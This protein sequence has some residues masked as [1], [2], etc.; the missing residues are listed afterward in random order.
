MPRLHPLKYEMF[1]IKNMEV[2]PQK[3]AAPGMIRLYID[4]A[5]RL[6]T[7]YSHGINIALSLLRKI[8]RSI[9]RMCPPRNGRAPAIGALD[10]LVKIRRAKNLTAG[11]GWIVRGFNFSRNA[12]IGQDRYSRMDTG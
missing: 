10:N 1:F 4:A 9:H 3:Y 6:H 5:C 12:D 11:I 2:T 7:R 8:H